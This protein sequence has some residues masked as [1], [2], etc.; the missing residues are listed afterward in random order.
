[1]SRNLVAI[2]GLA[3]A[4]AA[5]PN[6]SQAKG[7]QDLG[8]APEALNVRVAVTL[9]YRHPDELTALVAAQ[10]DRRSLLFRHYL[11][12]AQFN[13]YFAPAPAAQATVVT[14]LERAG[15][16]IE[17]TY[18][19]RTVVDAVASRSA[20]ERF[21]S[22]IIDAIAQPGQGVRYA[23]TGPAKIPPALRGLVVA[24]AGLDNLISFAPRYITG[25]APPAWPPSVGGPLKG[26]SGHYGPLAY[27]QGYDEPVQHGYDG[28]GRSIGT[29]MAGNLSDKDLRA[30]LRYF[31][32]RLKHPLVRIAVDG[33][34]LGRND[35]ETTLDVEAM[36]GT[37]PGAQLYLYSFPDFSDKAAE[38]TYNQV[39]SDN[40]VDVMNSSWGGCETD[41]G[42]L[43]RT[44]SLA[45]N[46][47]FEQGA[48]KGITFPIATG[49]Y[50]ADS[51]G[52]W[53]DKYVESSAG[54]DPYAL[55]VGGT[56][57]KVDGSGNWVSETGW[58]GS[59]G[60]VSLLFEQP[61]YQVGIAGTQ[62][63]GRNLPDIALAAGATS[64]F[65]IYYRG[66]WAPVW[67]TSLSSPLF[68]GME[69]QIDQFV[70][71]RIGF[72]NPALYGV[73]TGSQYGVEFHDIVKGNNG[74]PASPGY[75]L[76]TGIGSPI[77]WAL[78]ESRI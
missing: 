68:A 31:G 3:G 25:N 49:D 61:Y 65:D 40:L 5:L 29:S 39:V 35:V 44:F 21:F 7:L 51:C 12:N 55:A 66:R 57:L 22:V 43:G 75:D 10:S 20:A 8:R 41:K 19:N 73:L 77:G 54:S 59:A 78:A 27:A 30:Y 52:E 72:V 33:G 2:A 53:R 16:R 63:S 69:G 38:D 24:V 1:M 45:S 58:S 13:A 62:P 47:I 18:P 46:V 67:G 74:Y 64:A 28:S 71:S 50:G 42:R 15:F 34:A 11:T 6:A 9:A 26:G 36:A 56:E 37:T 76:V 23:S 60:G 17:H 70:G 32:T 14:A 48:S 4:L